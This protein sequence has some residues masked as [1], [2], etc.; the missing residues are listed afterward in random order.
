MTKASSVGAQL[1]ALM[2]N[3]NKSKN[4]ETTTTT[5]GDT[6][7]ANPKLAKYDKMKKIGM[8]MAS[9]I[10]RMRMDQCTPDLIAEFKGEKVDNASSD[11]EGSSG[12]D[13]TD[14]DA[15]VI[16]VNDKRFDKYKKMKK[17]GMPQASIINKMR[18]DGFAKEDINAFEE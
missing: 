10:N 18:M 3:K 6:N 8:P 5:K 15:P 13:E 14:D 11:D 17:I 7:K 1:Q 9:I 16:D 2:A 4:S 12:S